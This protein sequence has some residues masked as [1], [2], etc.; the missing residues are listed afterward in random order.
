MGLHHAVFLLL[1]LCKTRRSNLNLGD[2]EKICVSDPRRGK[3]FPIVAL[4]TTNGR[5][6]L[7]K[8]PCVDAILAT[9]DAVLAQSTHNLAPA[10]IR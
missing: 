2:T 7:L 4:I 9:R 3:T 5:R 10:K 6:F 8:S 1:L